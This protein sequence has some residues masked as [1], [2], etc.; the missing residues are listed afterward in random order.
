MSIQITSAALNTKNN[1]QVAITPTDVQILYNEVG[2]ELQK[3][4][5][6]AKLK[7]YHKTCS[8]ENKQQ[9]KWAPNAAM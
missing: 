6:A 5:E 4:L 8:Y 7:L 3:N 2:T 1:F 9:Q